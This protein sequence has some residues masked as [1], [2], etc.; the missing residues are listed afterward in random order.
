MDPAAAQKRDSDAG[1]SVGQ[2]LTIRA[3]DERLIACAIA[4]EPG[5]KPVWWSGL[6][7]AVAGA[8]GL[9]PR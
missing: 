8:I 2:L 4:S 1:Q 9:W 5:P 6:L 7:A 3:A